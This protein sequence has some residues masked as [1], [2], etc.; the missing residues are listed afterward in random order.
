MRLD[1]DH[2]RGG[3][4]GGVV[5]PV[6]KQREPFGKWDHGGKHVH[7]EGQRLLEVIPIGK[8]GEKFFPSS[9]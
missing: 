4:G 7:R 5:T 2:G 1:S 9:G 3:S 6:R 8:A